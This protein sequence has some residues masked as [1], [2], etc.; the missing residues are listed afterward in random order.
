MKNEVRKC[1][2]ILTNL[3]DSFNADREGT[4]FAYETRARKIAAAERIR[5]HAKEIHV[6]LYE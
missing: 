3:R 6:K 5:N 2:T 1:A 4:I